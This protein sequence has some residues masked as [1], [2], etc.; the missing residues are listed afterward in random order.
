MLLF[1]I[2]GGTITYIIVVYY[3]CI[4]SEMPDPPD[5]EEGLL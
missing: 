4:T 3:L 2:L 5:V 1:I